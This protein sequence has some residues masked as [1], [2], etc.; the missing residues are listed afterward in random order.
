MVISEDIN[1]LHEG[2]DGLSSN[3]KLVY[4]SL[5]RLKGENV[6]KSIIEKGKEYLDN[7]HMRVEKLKI[8]YGSF[9]NRI[10]E[11]CEDYTKKIEKIRLEDKK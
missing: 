4:N 1:S 9:S 6:N 7:E 8:A 2:L 5:T 3:Y 10:N 11:I